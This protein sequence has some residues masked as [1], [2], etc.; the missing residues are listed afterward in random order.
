[1]DSTTMTNPAA[2][3]PTFETAFYLLFFV[4]GF[5]TVW[6]YHK[7]A[8]KVLPNQTIIGV[9]GIIWG[10]INYLL[11]DFLSGGGIS[12]IQIS[13][14]N[15]IG[16]N[17]FSVI[18]F[19]SIFGSIIGFIGG[20]ILI[21]LETK[22]AYLL[23]PR[24]KKNKIGI[25][26]AIDTEKKK[27]KQ[28]LH[29]DLIEKI[30]NYFENTQL[31]P[32]FT[33]LALP[34]KHA[35]RIKNAKEAERYLRFMKG[36]LIVYGTICE[37]KYQGK[38]HYFF[39]LNG[40]V[41]HK[42]IPLETSRK[43]GQEFGELMPSKWSFDSGNEL[44]GFQITQEWLD[45]VTK[46]IIGI[47]FL[48]SNKYDDAEQIFLSLARE[49]YS[50]ASA[51]PALLE[52]KKRLPFRLLEIADIQTQI[53]YSRYVN[54]RD[55]VF[56]GSMKKYL[57]IFKRY[58]PNYYR[59]RLL[60]SIYLFL[61]HRDIKGAMKELRGV[62]MPLDTTWRYNLAF[63]LAYQGNLKQAKRQYDKAFEGFTSSNAINDTE[64]FMSDIMGKEKDKYCLLFLRG[65]LNLKGKGDMALAK[66]DFENFIKIAEPT[67]Y[68][69]EIRIAGIYV[70]QIEKGSFGEGDD[71]GL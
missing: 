7:A 64:V 52:I 30:R 66:Q 59:A 3:M 2:G 37:R 65:Y 46:Y 12:K 44:F 39:N 69:E 47:S 17:I 53:L 55:N 23:L 5:I 22:I 60:N 32:L 33:V 29:K 41:I 71:L 56:I 28:R 62:K 14:D 6:A 57:D 26:I 1:M 8:D 43:L 21:L 16:Q 67:K 50:M 11:Y 15:N 19:M 40:V 45:F 10:I 27:E 58:E 25:I 70:E 9:F 54:S 35:K 61:I 31:S 63:L 13:L 4:P 49:I 20:K 48:V 68:A 34:Q 42:L 38:D 36:N 24:N 18:I 51:V